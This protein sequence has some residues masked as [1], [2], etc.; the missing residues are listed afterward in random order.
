MRVGSQAPAGTVDEVFICEEVQQELD[1]DPL[2]ALDFV[3]PQPH[4]QPPL[5]VPPQEQEALVEE[6]WTRGVTN[7]EGCS[8]YWMAMHHFWGCWHAGGG[9]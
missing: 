7:L 8:W 1:E 5:E 2:E 9:V 4:P 6:A 3:P